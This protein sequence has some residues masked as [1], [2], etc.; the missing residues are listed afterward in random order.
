MSKNINREGWSN[1]TSMQ[2]HDEMRDYLKSLKIRKGESLESVLKRIL[3]TIE[4]H[5]LEIITEEVL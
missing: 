3:A 1:I 5:N 4:K 2:I